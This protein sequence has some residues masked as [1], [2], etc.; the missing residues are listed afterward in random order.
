MDYALENYSSFIGK[1]TSELPTPSFIVSLPVLKQ[2]IETLHRDVEKHGI[3]FRPHVKTLKVN[4][5]VK[6]YLTDV[7]L[8]ALLDH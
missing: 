7:L 5:S 4:R 1:P 3:L 8:I 6:K 2:N